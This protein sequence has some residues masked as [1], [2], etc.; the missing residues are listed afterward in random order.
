MIAGLILAAGSGTRFGSGPKLLADLQGRPLLE[1]AVRA[2]IAVP[3][4]ERVVVVLGAHAE[5]LLAAVDFGRGETLICADWAAGQGVSL[6]QGLGALE[7]AEKV[8]VTLGDQP[9]ISPGLIARFLPQAPGTRAV[10]HGRPGHPVVLGAAEMAALSS[11]R[12]DTGARDQL[13]HGAT[14]ECGRLGTD[15]DVDTPEQLEALRA[16]L[17]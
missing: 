9:L 2:Q 13:R 7:G 17:G 5:Q 8:I 3:E 15:A 1:H 6:R 10:Y 11:H 14:I 4:L 12:G 16:R